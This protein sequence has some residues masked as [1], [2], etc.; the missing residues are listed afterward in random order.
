MEDNKGL[1]TKPIVEEKYPPSNKPVV[2]AKKTKE[3]EEG[4]KGEE[5]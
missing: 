4:K 3:D 2:E 1:S 5:L